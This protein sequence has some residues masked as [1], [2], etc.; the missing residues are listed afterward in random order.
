MCAR[1][2]SRRGFH[3]DVDRAANVFARRGAPGVLVCAHLDDLG[4]PSRRGVG[5]M[6]GALY[7]ITGAPLGGDDK[8]GVAIAMY[9]A[10][11]PDLPLTVLLTTQEEVGSVGCQEFLAHSRDALD[12]VMAAL[13][14]DRRGTCD[15]VVN[16]CGV[17]F[18]PQ[19]EWTALVIDAGHEVGVPSRA[20]TGMM[21]DAVV[22]ADA[23]IPVVN[24]SVGYRL[25]H[26]PAEHVY[27]HDVYASL[28]WVLRALR[29]AGSG[30]AAPRSWG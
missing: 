20:V 27:L 16:A 17:E 8:C 11:V 30:V 21:S 28:R 12:G 6:D 29:K 13:V 25:P 15:V 2:F 24:V 9:L 26:T 19:G 4:H 22:L 5:M 1:F 23:G 10:C 14:L 7:S 18:D 3:V